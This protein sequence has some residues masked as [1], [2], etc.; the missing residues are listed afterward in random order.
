MKKGRFSTRIL[1]VLQRKNRATKKD[2]DFVNK[3]SQSKAKALHSPLFTLSVGEIDPTKEPRVSFIIGKKISGLATERNKI[4]RLFRESM[5]I[6]A[7]RLKK[8]IFTSFFIKKEAVGK[9]HKEIL[10]EIY[11]ALNKARLLK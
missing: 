3:N 11:S 7:P 2:F 10:E 5:R 1:L 8:G 4:K 6:F 9:K